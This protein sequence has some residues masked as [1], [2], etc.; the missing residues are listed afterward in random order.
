MK[1]SEIFDQLTQGEL[2]H[3]HMS[4]ADSIG[5]EECDYPK[6][7]PHVNMALA[8][9]YKRFT[10]KVDS[11]VLQEY[12]TINKYPLLIENA[13][14]YSGINVNP[15]FIVDSVAYPFEE[16]ITVI[17][18]ILGSDGEPLSLNDRTDSEALRTPDYRT[19]YIPSPKEG[20]LLTVRYK[21][22]H[23]HIVIQGLKPFETE[24]NLPYTLLQP[25]LLFVASRVMT[26][27]NQD[28]AVTEGTNL[29]GRFEASVQDILR[30]G[31][32]NEKETQENE[33]LDLAGWA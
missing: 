29:M 33:K 15:R 2:T 8:E 3:M 7:V 23:E 5:I 1:L 6:I 32:V 9:L 19:V 28:G 31:L 4:G 17:E 13:V 12:E 24:V 21:A 30:L 16:N 14:S 20:N 11:L 10:L 18:E 25:L 26:N 22:S 27:L